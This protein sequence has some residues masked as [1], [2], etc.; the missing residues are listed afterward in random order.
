MKSLEASLKSLKAALVAIWSFVSRLEYQKAESSLDHDGSDK[1]SEYP[2]P[3]GWLNFFS[4]VILCVFFVTPIAYIF[5]DLYI[6]HFPFFL[7]VASWQCIFVL[8]L[9]NT[10]NN[11]DIKILLKVFFYFLLIFFL[12]ILKQFIFNLICFQD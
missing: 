4:F 11:H 5:L 2:F 3:E 8:C 1:N 9:I 12:L 10:T 6:I 7:L